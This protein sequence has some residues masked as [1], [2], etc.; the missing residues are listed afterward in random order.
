ML[1]AADTYFSFMTPGRL[2]FLRHPLIIFAA[3]NGPRLAGHAV[4]VGAIM[5]DHY[6]GDPANPYSP[7]LCVL[8]LV[9]VG[10]ATQLSI[11]P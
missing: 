5:K 10:A 3:E 1:G 4:Q 6:R 9:L 11:L 2:S 8:L 7:L